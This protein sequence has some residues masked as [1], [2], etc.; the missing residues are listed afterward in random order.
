MFVMIF[1]TLGNHIPK[2]PEQSGGMDTPSRFSFP[3]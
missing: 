1:K 3:T 2:G